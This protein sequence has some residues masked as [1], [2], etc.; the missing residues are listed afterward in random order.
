MEL[1]FSVPY[2]YSVVFTQGVFSV[3]NKALRNVLVG[4]AP[5]VRVLFAVETGVADLNPGLVDAITAYCDANAD[6]IAQAGAPLLLP[7]GEES[8]TMTSVLKVCEALASRHLCRH[9][10]L[11]IVGG[12]AFLDIC[13]LAAGLF[14][15]GMRQVR[16]PTTGLSQCDSGVGVKNG[17]NA[18]DVKNLLGT[19]APPCAVINDADFLHSLTQEMRTAAACEAVKVAM[20]KDAVFF[21]FLTRNAT[22]IANGEEAPVRGMVRR[23]A[24]IHAHHIATNGDPF[25]SGSAR[26]LD[27]GHWA[28]HHLEMLSHGTVPHG[29]AVGMGMLIDTLYAVR[30]GIAPASVFTALQNVLRE[31]RLPFQARFLNKRAG[32]GHL[33][34]LDGIDAFREHLG[35]TLQITLPTAIGAKI[36]VDSIDRDI[37]TDVISTLPGL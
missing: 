26:P 32:D 17:V 33:L 36:E 22:A 10:C 16:I 9:S 24:E 20:I 12:G 8:K 15:R 18:F 28:A 4:L 25:E 29:I 14:H 21:D 31:L 11:A 7:G 34:I 6:V 2:E 30:T 37:M 19:F 13:G 23:S 35:G 3:G 5:P 27:F 1:S